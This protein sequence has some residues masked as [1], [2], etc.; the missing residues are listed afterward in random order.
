MAETLQIERITLRFGGLTILDEVS[1]AVRA[2][3]LLALIGPNGAGKTSILNCISGIYRISEGRI[4]FNGQDIAGLAPHRVAQLGI[5]RT[6]QH[7]ELFPE[8]SV[9]DNILVGRHAALRSH[10]LAEALFLPGVRRE[11]IRNREV[12]EEILD[13]VELERY[14]HKAVGSLPFG[15]QKLVGFARALA[16]QPQVLLLD[17]PCAG[18]NREDREDLARHIMRIQHEKRLPMIWVEHDMQMV[19]D[20][21]DRLYVLDHGQVL[22]QGEPAKVLNDPKVIEAYIGHSK[23]AQASTAIDREHQIQ[24]GLLHAAGEAVRSGRPP[25]EVAAI[26]DQLASYNRAHFASEELLMR[27]YR[28][29]ELELH[30]VDHQR[31][32][33]ELDDIVAT[34]RAG[35]EPR[36]LQLTNELEDFL[37]QHI[38]TRDGRFAQY[39]AHHDA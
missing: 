25:A 12:V 20:L 35:D 2:G 6:F 7:A 13:F 32:M 3:E 27:L 23:P 1:L 16:Y 21:A 4:R 37:L 18:L 11:E 29:P 14:R 38:A 31:M 34:C 33:D 26:V 8:M 15:I 36:T 28:Y 39:L 10:P 9:L 5:A 22:A 30:A 24:T 17:E 19:A